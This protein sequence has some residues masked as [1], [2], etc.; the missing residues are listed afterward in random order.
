[1]LRRN[2]FG[3]ELEAKKDRIFKL[4]INDN[5]ELYLDLEEFMAYTRAV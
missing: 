1:M 2:Q 3:C 4:V 5:I